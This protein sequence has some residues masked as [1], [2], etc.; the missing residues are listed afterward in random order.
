LGVAK[1]FAVESLFCWGRLAPEIGTWVL[2]H[3]VDERAR[4]VP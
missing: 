1:Y 2:G 3:E 4:K